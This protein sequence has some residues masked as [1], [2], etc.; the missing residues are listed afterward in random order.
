MLA[1]DSEG[2]VSG[3]ENLFR[4]GD[5]FIQNSMKISNNRLLS[6]PELF[7]EDQQAK[8]ECFNSSNS[9]QLITIAVG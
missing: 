1:N 4:S 9:S 8:P 6:S 3:R 7:Q 5:W 2:R